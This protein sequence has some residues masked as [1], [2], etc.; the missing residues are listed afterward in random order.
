M[1]AFGLMRRVVA[2]CASLLISAPCLASDPLLILTPEGLAQKK[3][4]LIGKAVQVDG[5]VYVHAHGMYV[6][7]CHEHDWYQ[8]T[9]ATDP[10]D[11]FIAALGRVRKP[12]SDLVVD[13]SL[14]A[15]IYG[16]I[17]NQETDWPERGLKP[18]LRIEQMTHV[19]KH[20]P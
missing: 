8:I 13:T 5:C 17:V 11:L 18:A 16:H 20:E 15:R 19:R 10:K 12:R 3:D 1:R 4:S 7:P 2:A 14:E 9:L 6:G